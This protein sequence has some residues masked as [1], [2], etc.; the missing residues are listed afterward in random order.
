MLLVPHVNVFPCEDAF[1][2]NFTRG[3]FQS[4]KSIDQV[5]GSEPLRKEFVVK[6]VV[7]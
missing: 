6:A 2:M 5:Q 7:I 1:S 3:Y 4:F